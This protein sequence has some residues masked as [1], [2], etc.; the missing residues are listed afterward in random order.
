MR[1]HLKV[2]C[3]LAAEAG[4]SGAVFKEVARHPVVFPGAG[5]ALHCFT[6]VAAM[7]LCATLTGRP[8]QDHRE[9]G[10]KRHRDEGGLAVARYSLDADLLRVHGGVG[11]KVVQAARRAPGPGTQRSPVIGL[12]GL[13]SV[14]ETDDAFSQPSAVVRLDAAR[15]DGRVAPSR[16]DQ[17]D[18][19]SVVSGK[20]VDL[21]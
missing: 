21:G 2:A 13:A 15:I 4:F 7:Q 3:V 8:H 5:K 20:S 12:A 18:R 19:T 16:L 9:T 10:L 1:I 6:E 17:L 14:N 11:F